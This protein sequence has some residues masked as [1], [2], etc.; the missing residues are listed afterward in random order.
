MAVPAAR[1]AAEAA[2]ISRRF[3]DTLLA[4]VGQCKLTV[5]QPVL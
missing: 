2:D 5:S 4:M 3:L 1:L